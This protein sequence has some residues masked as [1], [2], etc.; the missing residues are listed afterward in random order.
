MINMQNNGGIRWQMGTNFQV[1]FNNNQFQFDNTTNAGNECII[2]QV[3]NLTCLGVKN[4]ATIDPVDDSRA[5]Y[6]AALEGPEAGTYF[7]GRGTI[8]DGEAVIELPEHF[9]KVTEVEGMTVHLT[10]IGAWAQLY[11][12]ESTPERLVVRQAGSEEME[13][14][15]FSFL[16]QGVRMGYSEYEV[17][18]SSANLIGER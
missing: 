18:R 13:D 6:Y 12:A 16:V 17:M 9:T 14:V 1:R 8:V 7:R 4:F 5:I 3:G 15:S 10:P 2:D 11:V